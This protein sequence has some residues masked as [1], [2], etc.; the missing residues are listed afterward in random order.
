MFAGAPTGELLAFDARNGRLLW[1][2]Q[3][4]SGIHANPITYSVRGIQYVAVPS[5]WGGWLK[6][7]APEL[8]GASRGSALF[9][10]ALP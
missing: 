1:R 8:L 9:A 7:F 5:G 10:F 2:Y 4:G 6:G 3:T